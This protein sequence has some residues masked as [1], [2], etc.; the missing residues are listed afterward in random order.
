MAVNSSIKWYM[1]VC[2]YFLPN[3]FP[4]FL[5][6]VLAN[7]WQNMQTG[8]TQEKL[9]QVVVHEASQH[10]ALHTGQQLLALHWVHLLWTE[11]VRPLTME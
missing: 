4:V 11:E 6:T 7:N 3:V 1:Q 8:K 5:C 2:D 10:L 9:L